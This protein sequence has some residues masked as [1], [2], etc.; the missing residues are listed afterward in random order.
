MDVDKLRHLLDRVA[1]QQTDVSEALTE[2]A[3]LPFVDLP[4]ARVDHHR[5]LRQGIPEVVFAQ[6]KTS[7]QVVGIIAELKRRGHGVLATRLQ[8]EHFG[9]LKRQF[10]DLAV[11]EFGRTALQ[12]GSVPA[13]RA[14]A[15]VLV[16]TAGTSDLPIA[17]E[18]EAT[19]SACGIEPE[20]VTDVGVAGLHR[21]LPEV[22]RLRRAHAV[23]V[24][25][26]M[27]GA[28]ASVVGGL[29]SAPVIAV[30]T[31]VGYGAA[32]EGVAALLGMLTSCAAGVTV[33]NIDNGFGA[34]IAAVRMVDRFLVVSADEGPGGEHR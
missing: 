28:L 34:A 19:L 32:F 14:H 4:F 13:H 9:A 25:A 16:V 18:A 11:D 12:R 1:R 33:V 31:S 27:E 29:V 10:P 17:A 7:D 2:L 22:E 6:G 3:E 5:T 21:L 30:P 24:I 20:R 15:K 23:I 8:P 26:G